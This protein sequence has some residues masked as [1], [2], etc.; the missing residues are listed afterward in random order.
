MNIRDPRQPEPKGAPVPVVRRSVGE[1]L[2]ALWYTGFRKDPGPVDADALRAR[3]ERWTVRHVA[4]KPGMFQSFDPPEPYHVVREGDF[5]IVTPPRSRALR[6][7][8]WRFSPGQAEL[9]TGTALFARER[10][11]QVFTYVVERIWIVHSVWTNGKGTSDALKIRG[12]RAGSRIVAALDYNFV[13][14][15][16]RP[17]GRGF[18]WSVSP[19]LEGLDADYG[20]PQ[21]ISDD[22]QAVAPVA[23]PILALGTLIA[24]TTGR[25]VSSHVEFIRRPVYADG[26]GD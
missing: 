12:P 13:H 4:N 24:E 2:A 20:A 3:V 25:P 8:S 16:M 6:S 26:P 9:T 22:V 18:G 7:E 1:R 10:Q 15:V 17:P 21:G 23:P 5:L 14:N 19:T 11:P